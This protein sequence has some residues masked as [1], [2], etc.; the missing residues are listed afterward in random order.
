[1]AVSPKSAFGVA[2]SI[3]DGTTSETFNPI[4]GIRT[5]DGP[6]GTMETID[7]TSHTSTGAT[8]EIVPSFLDP[9]TVSG[10]VIL[11]STDTY[12][13]QM[14]T[15]RASRALR[16]FE[17]VMTDTG[18]LQIDYAAYITDF[19]PSNPIDDAVTASFQLALSG[20]WTVS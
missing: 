1:M 17:Q 9:G 10:T 16:N 6:T 7:A 20:A 19:S 2:L 13:S 5:L 14:I 11:D 18:A 3:G 8:R 12:Q 15:D 4:P